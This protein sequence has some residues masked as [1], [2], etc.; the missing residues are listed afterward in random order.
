MQIFIPSCGRAKTI[1]THL[2][3]KGKVDYKIVVHTD[4]EACA[5]LENDTVPS[6]KIIVSGQPFSISKQRNWILKNLAEPNRF[7][8]MLDDN[9]SAFTAVKEDVY[10]EEDLQKK[11]P[12]PFKKNDVKFKNEFYEQEISFERMNLIFMELAAKA[13][14]VGATF[15]AFS[16]N[17]NYYFSRAKKWKYTQ[18]I[19][20]KACIIK[21]DGMMYDENVQ[22]IDDYCMS[23]Q[24]MIRDGKVLVNAYVWPKSKHNQKGGLGQISERGSK[25][26]E[27][28]KYL[29][30]KYPGL[31]RIKPRKNSVAGGEVCLRGYGKFFENWR[32]EYAKTIN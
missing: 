7:C 26:I 15:A 8:A 25:K 11:Y 31:L 23:I 29:L 9:I 19:C 1:K 21:N 24:R 12:D 28:V 3:L 18:L 32:N 4:D 17:R 20:S 27:D 2:I 16:A 14:E 10:M 22:T 5:Y 30:G 6:D 13:T